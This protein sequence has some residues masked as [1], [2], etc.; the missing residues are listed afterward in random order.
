MT[1]RIR[2]KHRLFSSA[3]VKYFIVLKTPL[4]RSITLSAIVIDDESSDKEDGFRF[5]RDNNTFKKIIS[6]IELSQK[7]SCRGNGGAYYMEANPLYGK[8]H[9]VIEEAIIY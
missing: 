4:F 6:T 5:I 7:G 8:T 1:I 2:I 9:D 3:K